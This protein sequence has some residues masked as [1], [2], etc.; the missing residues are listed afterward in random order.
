MTLPQFLQ[1]GWDK[2]DENRAIGEAVKT[3]GSMTTGGNLPFYSFRFRNI[4]MNPR[5]LCFFACIFL[6]A[7]GCNAGS[8]SAS[9][10][11]AIAEL[12]S[13][14]DDYSRWCALGHATKES[15]NQ[16]HDA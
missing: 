4:P 2:G 14:K 16:G 7:T 3:S 12:K 5:S 10:D 15:L 11:K 8:D 9:Y 6:C 13:A 1:L